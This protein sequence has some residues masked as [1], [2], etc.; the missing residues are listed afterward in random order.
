M[1]N[2]DEIRIAYQVVRLGT[3]SAAAEALGLHRA[4][5]IRHIDQLEAA[6]GERLF[7][8]HGR[9]YAPTDAGLELM[10]VAQAAEDQFE[11]L[12][13]RLQSQAQLAAGE[14]V[15]TSLPVV[16]Q[17][18]MPALA[19][20]RERHPEVSLRH[21]SSARTLKLERGEAHV[22]VRAGSGGEEPDNVVQPF[23]TFRMGLFASRDYLD[24]RGTPLTVADL[25]AH[26]FVAPID[27]GASDASR[28]YLDRLS[29]L[30]VEPRVA[31]SSTNMACAEKAVT[32]G[33]GI[34]IMPI[35]LEKRPELVHI[36]LD[37]ELPEAHLMLVTHVDL[38]RTDKVQ[39]LLS[40]LKTET[41]REM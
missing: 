23:R 19:V 5:V 6:L 36:P 18:I 41:P 8:R 32:N 17:L 31:F 35:A 3:V 2:W 39:A 14:L 9:G 25:S 26:L 37:V 7:L 34:G 30:A 15:L 11:Q 40:A 20:F 29:T 13:A 12:A 22:A 10:R 28:R 24:R 16:T 27:T 21:I 4:T 38:H 33:L 1:Q